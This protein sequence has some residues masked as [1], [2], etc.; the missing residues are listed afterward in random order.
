MHVPC[1]TDDD[2]D[3]MLDSSPK[4]KTTTTTTSRRGP[5]SGEFANNLVGPRTQLR[6]TILRK[7]AKTF[8]DCCVRNAPLYVHTY[9]HMYVCMYETFPMYV[10]LA[11]IYLTKGNTSAGG[12]FSHIM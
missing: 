8:R 6:N 9:I 7:R 3:D 4:R 1:H 11:P 10:V 2:D 5:D 12:A